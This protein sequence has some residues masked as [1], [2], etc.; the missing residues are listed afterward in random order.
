MTEPARLPEPVERRI[1][2]ALLMLELGAWVFPL[3]HDSKQPLV[4]KAKGGHGFLDA[5]PDPEM[6][7]RFLSNPGQ[8]N[9]GVAFPEGSD[10]IV[11]DIDGGAS[12]RAGWR[13]D[14]QRLY[15]LYGPPGL[16]L[17][18]KTPSG[19]RHAYYRWRQDV[20]GPIP[21][22]DEMLGWT[23]RKPW[24]GYLVGPGSVVHGV[25]YEITGLR[26]IAALSDAWCR[27][28]LDEKRDHT[29]TFTAGGAA[30]ADIRPGHRHA[31]LRDRARHLRGVGLSGEGLFAA[32][33][34][35]NRQLAEPKTEDEVRQ[36][37]G[38]VESKFEPDPVEVDEETG[39][40]TTRSPDDAL[41]ILPAAGSDA[42][43]EPPGRAAFGGLLGECVH[44]LAGGTDASL[45]GLLGSMVAICGALVPGAAYFHR[46]QTSSPFVALVGESSVGRKG[47]AM[48]RVLDA[49]A[50]ATDRVTINRVILDG[51]NSGEGLVSSLAYRQEHFSDAV[52]GLVFEEEYASLLASRSREG[53]TLDPKMRAAFDGGPL[54]NRRSGDTKTVTPPYWLPALIAITPDELRFRLE[55]GAFMSGSANR[56]LYLPV[57]RRDIVP[58]NEEPR[59][60]GEHRDAIAAA[61]RASAMDSH[62]LGVDPVVTRVLAEYADW[63]SGASHGLSKDL[64]KRLAVIAFR[65]AL[66]HALIERSSTVTAAHLER[67]LALTEYARSGIRWVFGNTIG[68]RD[69][70]LLLRHLIAAGR[71][72]K[73]TISREVIRD[74]LRL[75]AAIDELQRWGHAHVET[76]V[77][78][79][80]RPRTE[81]VLSQNGA[82]V[83]VFDSAPLREALIRGQNG[84]KSVNGTDKSLPKGVPEASQKGDT[85]IVG[86][87]PSRK[88]DWLR[89]CRDYEAHRDHHRNTAGGWTCLACDKD[90][91]S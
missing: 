73:R 9:Y 51:L 59:F 18:V 39:Q 19:G 22:G 57:V 49:M 34:D 50:D 46:V 30:P 28:A 61:R 53:S 65:V 76:V 29:I 78:T 35:L 83:Q 91:A 26:S 81:L 2:L 44:D 3:A 42:F 6:A 5:S 4:P 1:E 77:E 25:Q 64:T 17:I 55:S 84:Q 27:A 88:P 56:W 47:T 79:G 13:D 40:V 21:P 11:L 82:F 38:D 80:G 75:Q 52:V 32:V 72:R 10:V 36:A 68:N 23:V 62:P 16:T 58:T 67:S 12:D 41:G 60:S 70:D 43:P 8:V 54:S 20:H 71:L 45:V 90:A 85:T 37:I 31:Y 87:A 24:K 33:M 66:V 15:D 7:R 89:P 74:P 48:T 69:A 14:W 63:L 86:V